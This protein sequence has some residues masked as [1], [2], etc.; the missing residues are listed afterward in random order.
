M[1]CP[2]H[3]QQT[4][5]AGRK[6]TEEVAPGQGG[7]SRAVERVPHELLDLAPHIMV[8]VLQQ[9]AQG[10]RTEGME[11]RPVLGTGVGDCGAAPVPVTKCSPNPTTACC[12]AK[13]C[14]SRGAALT[15]T[16]AAHPGC[17]RRLWDG[18][19]ECSGLR[20]QGSGCRKLDLRAAQVLEVSKRRG[21][22][23]CPFNR[24]QVACHGRDSP[25]RALHG[26]WSTP[27]E[28]MSSGQC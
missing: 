15:P 2:G 20:H 5:A 12:K 4:L 1:I 9:P 24:Q 19:P 8:V 23:T 22:L 16:S 21:S 14:K 10:G 6:A 13:R 26:S 7:N 18:A 27:S 17:Q 25:P 11:G 28:M 3:G